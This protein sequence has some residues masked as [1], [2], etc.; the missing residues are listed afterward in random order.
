[1]K[2]AIV[3]IGAIVMGL[4]GVIYENLTRRIR[5]M[6]NWKEGRPQDILTFPDHYK[7]CKENTKE[8]RESLIRELT[9]YMSIKFDELKDEIRTSNGKNGT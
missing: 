4:I 6:E 7:F 5:N 8:L 2:E 3:I 9:G 1:M